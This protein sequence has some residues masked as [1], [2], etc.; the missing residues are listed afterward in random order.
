MG[1]K[2]LHTADLHLDSPFAAFP[3]AARER[4]RAAQLRLPELLVSACRREGADILLLAGDVFDGPYRK[5]TAR[6]L[7]D[8]LEDCA[9]PVFLA[10]GNHDFYAS[11]APWQQE[12]WPENVHIFT[13]YMSYVDLEA[14]DCRV[15]GA[16]YTSMDCPGLLEG[17]RAE[18]VFAH[19]LAV[20]HGDPL[21][22]KSP[23]CPVTARQVENSGL[24]YLALGHIHK[25]GSLTAG[26]TLCAWPG[27]PMGRG[28]DETGR[29]GLLLA[30]LGDKATLRTLALP[31]PAF[32]EETVSIEPG[33]AQ[34]LSAVLPAAAAEDFYRVTLTGRGEVALD[35]LKEQF[36]YLPGLELRDRTLPRLDPWEKAGQDSFR[37]LYFTLLKEKLS[38]PELADA[39]Q[40]A[41]E[42]SQ[43]ILDGEEVAL[44]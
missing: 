41:A 22:A 1:L 42:L 14:L 39:A 26:G 32:W 36:S 15:Y 11:G 8:A 17:F 2:I 5:S 27:C 7:A 30:E 9:V 24:D 19:T 20:L 28:W 13:G 44:P 18:R 31:L 43:K 21:N 35:A 29:K 38:N 4:L 33:A 12:L 23:Y 37:G 3:E 10:P 34:A 16:G 6:A 25:G 40:L